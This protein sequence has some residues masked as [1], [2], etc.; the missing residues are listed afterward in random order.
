MIL[1]AIW[2]G[3][4]KPPTELYLHA[5]VEEVKCLSTHGMFFSSDEHDKASGD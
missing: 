4:T 1:A 2:C 3:R 5:F